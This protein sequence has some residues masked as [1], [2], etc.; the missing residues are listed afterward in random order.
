VYLTIP[1]GSTAETDAYLAA[2]ALAADIDVATFDRGMTRFPG[3]RV[4]DPL[5]P[6]D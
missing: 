4:I 5:R 1:R 2:F 3:V 6:G